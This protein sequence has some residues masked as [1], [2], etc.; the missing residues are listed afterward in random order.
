MNDGE[1][2]I[3]K[4]RMRISSSSNLRRIVMD[5]IH[6]TPYARHLGYKKMIAIARKQYFHPRMKTYI[7]K[8]VKVEYQHP[9]GLLYS[10]YNL[11]WKW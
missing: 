9:I 11:E 6:K 7:S 8:Q 5:G 1:P 4:N 10:L 2:F 3:Y